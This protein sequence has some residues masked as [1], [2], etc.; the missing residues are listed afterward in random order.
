MKANT[1]SV[2]DALAKSHQ[3]H[4]IVC[5]KKHHR[6]NNPVHK[7]QHKRKTHLRHCEKKSTSL[8]HTS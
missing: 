8:T 2:K 3:F 4:S 1:K 5:P 7:I 6:E